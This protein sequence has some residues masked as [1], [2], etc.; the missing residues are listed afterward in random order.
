MELKDR[1]GLGE[2]AKDTEKNYKIY[3]DFFAMVPPLG[4][5]G[6]SSAKLCDF[7][8]KLCGIKRPQRTRRSTKDAEKNCKF[9]KHFSQWFTLWGLGGFSCAKLCDFSVKLCGIKRPQRTRRRH[10]RHREKLQ[11]L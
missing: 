5:G 4:L 8:A 1:R 9:Y 6:F 2:G 7:S 3:K 11:N 10:K